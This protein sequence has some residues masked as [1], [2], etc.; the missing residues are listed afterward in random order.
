MKQKF[1]IFIIHVSYVC[2][3]VS[4]RI[5]FLKLLIGPQQERDRERL[6]REGMEGTEQM[7]ETE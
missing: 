5:K 3:C 6:E 7:E 4:Y 2:T 1:G